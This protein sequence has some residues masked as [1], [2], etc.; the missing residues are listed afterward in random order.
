MEFLELYHTGG[1]HASEV[2]DDIVDSP[3]Y[4]SQIWNELF[5][6]LIVGYEIGCNHNKLDWLSVD[7]GHQYSYTNYLNVKLLSLS[8]V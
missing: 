8:K 4:I 5:S 6:M 3:E 1:H 7:V 2:V